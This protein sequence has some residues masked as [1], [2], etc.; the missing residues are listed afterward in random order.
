[1]KFIITCLFTI[2][3]ALSGSAQTAT[4]ILAKANGQNFTVADLPADLRD[5]Y[6]KMNK[7]SLDARRMFFNSQI[8]EILLE[9]EAKVRKISVDDLVKSVNSKVANPTEKQIQDVYDKNKDALGGRSLA[10]VREQIVAFLRREPEQ[11]A[12]NVLVMSLAKK[13][14]VG[15]FKDVNARNLKATDILATI[16]GRN[17]TVGG[18]EAKNRVA[19]YEQK[20]EIFDEIKLILE[21]KI[22][23]ALIAAEAKSEKIDASD[24]IAREISDKLRDFTDEEREDLESNFRRK[25][26]TKYNTQFLLKEPAPLVLQVSAD[27]DPSK[28][29]ATAPVTVVMFSDFQC[30]SCAAAHPVLQKVLAEYPTEKVR[31]VVRDFPLS[32]IHANAFLA[33]TAANAAHKQGKFFEFTDVLYRNQNALD[34]ESLKKYAADL[35]LNPTQFE[36]DLQSESNAAEI[37]KDMSDGANYGISGTPTIYV[38]GVK[39]RRNTAEYFR[40]AI[41]KVLKK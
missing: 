7:N 22:Y 6:L 2:I 16:N 31:F 20:A 28:G 14:K 39:V 29:S 34:K 15:V 38:N 37:R 40:A 13:Y 18:F 27:D 3:F 5:A 8:G 19:L 23:N 21:E 36:L 26:F 25:L 9:T 1:M 11:K 12:L 33:A 30:S 24:L 41:D 4:Q 35:G 10:E 32:Q 17:I